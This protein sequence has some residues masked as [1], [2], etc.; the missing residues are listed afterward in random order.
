MDQTLISNQSIWDAIQQLKFDMFSHFDAKMD[1]IQSALQTI[2]GSLSTLGDH[3]SELEQRVSTNEDNVT[4]L[5][6][7][8]KTLLSENSYLRDKVED[9]ENRSR[10][11]NLRFLHVPEKSEG[12]DIIGFMRGLIQLLLGKENF[13]VPPVIERAHRSPTTLQT[14]KPKVG[15]RPI[16]VKFLSLQDKQLILRLSREKKELKYKGN[17]VH[18]FPD[19]SAGIVQKRR[20][21]D[22]IKKKLRELKMEYS[23]QYPAI[24]RI[25]AAGKVILFKSPG[26]AESFLRDFE[27][28]S[29][30]D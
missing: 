30:N 3:V 14:N 11:Y 26:D 18:I 6:K 19:F 24:L 27:A 7:Y 20:Q 5:Q 28:Q 2:Q 17:R 21:F 8:V 4:E 10:A 1:H 16:L 9:A 23:L 15:P 22:D 29:Q 12:Q 13:V 25:I